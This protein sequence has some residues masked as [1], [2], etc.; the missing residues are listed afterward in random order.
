MKSK[1]QKTPV[2]SVVRESMRQVLLL[3][4]AVRLVWQSTPV[5]TSVNIGLVIA[6]GLLPVGSLWAMRQI[7]DSAA[8][9]VTERT[10]NPAIQPLVIWLAIAGL[11][12]VVSALARA[13]G[14]IAGQAQSTTVTDKISDILHAQSVHVDL[15]YYESPDYYDTMRRA[16][17][18]ATYR[19]TRIINGF[20]QIGQGLVSL[21]GI[22]GLLIVF[23]WRI[24]LVLLLA[25][26]PGALVRLT[27]S[28]KL[29]RL[30]IEQTKQERRAW[31][32][33]WLMTSPY[34]AKEIRLFGLGGL[35][36]TRFSSCQ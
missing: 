4:R 5:W 7:V 12:A 6:Q 20:L 34:Y 35:F 33:D 3:Q 24:A 1:S 27:Y 25:A 29:H 18:E 32:Y 10:T 30:E 21:L 23:D 15:E 28:R 19:P 17:G 31:Y 2:S 8:L 26:L 16:Q 9:V 14:E 36:Q 13:L 22:G 11:I